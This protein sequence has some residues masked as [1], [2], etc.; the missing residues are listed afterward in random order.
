MF[1]KFVSSVSHLVVVVKM[2]HLAEDLTMALE[3]S[4]SCGPM[5]C[6]AP[7]KWGMRRRTQSAGNLRGKLKKTKG[8]SSPYVGLC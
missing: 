4:E 6:P 5:V 3:E 8:K 1:E 7:G 2:E